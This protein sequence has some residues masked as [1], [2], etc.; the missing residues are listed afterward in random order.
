M[1]EPGRKRNENPGE[2]ARALAGQWA[3]SAGQAMQS[4]TVRKYTLP[5]K[6][7]ASQV[8][9][10]RQLLHTKCRPGLKLSR[11][12]QGTPAQKA[13][14][15]MPWWSKGIEESGTMEI[16]YDPLIR[17]LWLHGA[18]FPIQDSPNEVD[19]YLD[20]EGNPPVPHE[21]WVSRLGFQQTDPVTD[22]RS[23][24][25]LSLAMMV[26]IVESCPAVFARFVRPDGDAS[27]LP[28]GITSINCT[29]MMA[30]FLM[31]AKAVDRMDALLSQKPF[32]RM[33]ADP[34]ALLLCQE[35]A[36]DMLADVVVEVRSIRQAEAEALE[37]KD[38]EDISSS[39][40]KVEYVT[41][42]DFAHI[43]GVTEKRVE[44]DLLGAG[45]G[46]VAELRSIHSRLKTRYKQQLSKKLEAI[47]Q[48]DEG[49]NKQQPSI[50]P[51]SA[52]AAKELP[53]QVLQQATELGSK[54]SAFAGKM[55][56]KLKSPGFSLQSPIRATST[57][58]EAVVFEDGKKGMQVP[59]LENTTELT[60][61][62][63][64]DDVMDEKPSQIDDGDWV[65][66]EMPAT[67]DM[68]GNFSIGDDDEDL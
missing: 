40:D 36:M 65:E 20:D 54:A 63:E 2:K 48:K 47:Q 9:M 64:E 46:T 41:V 3:A 1:D 44:H 43:L 29:D 56:T 11:E 32:W 62:I 68:V 23:G 15:H 53:Q 58:S 17:R 50:R 35:L 19:T 12:Y 8:L 59:V 38:S 31:L 37:E 13:V 22:F 7:V 51:L 57:E 61:D 16:A 28:F 5:D 24:G 49:T 27:V 55:F 52:N 66:A 67:I 33:F 60:K 25:V 30:K 21:F 34:N 6:N 14:L 26:W 4:L 10:Y 18:I 39:K 45:P 42:F